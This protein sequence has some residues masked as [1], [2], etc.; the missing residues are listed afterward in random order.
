[1][2]KNNNN[3]KIIQVV[4]RTHSRTSAYVSYGRRIPPPAILTCYGRQDEASPDQR[5]PL[6]VLRDNICWLPAGTK[7]IRRCFPNVKKGINNSSQTLKI[8]SHWLLQLNYLVDSAGSVLCP[9]LSTAVATTTTESIVVATIVARL[10][11]FYVLVKRMP[12]RQY[13]Q[14]LLYS[15]RRHYFLELHL[16]ACVC[17]SSIRFNSTLK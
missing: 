9:L 4:V 15:S 13:Q 6:S 5:R 17:T 10:D 2:C 8:Q 11:L 16:L 3:K 12:A 1:M 14:T 7:H